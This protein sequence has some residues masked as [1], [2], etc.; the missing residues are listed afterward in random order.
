VA[1]GGGSAGCSTSSFTIAPSSAGGSM[2]YWAAVGDNNGDSWLEGFAP[3]DESV[4]TTLTVPSV[5]ATQYRDSGGNLVSG[6]AVECIGCHSAVPD[7][8]SVAFIDFY[9]WPGSAANVK[10]VG[11]AGTTGQVPSWMTPQGAIQLA[12]PWLGVVTFSEADWMNE[13]VAVTTYGCT[14]PS[15][16]TNLPWRNGCSNQTPSLIW[17]QLDAPQVPAWDAGGFNSGSTAIDQVMAGYGTTWGVIERTGDIAGNGAE[18]A[19]WSHDGSKILYVSTNA[20]KDGRLATGTADLYTVPFNDKKGGAATPVKGASDPA[21]AEYYG[22][23]SKDDS[24]IAFVSAKMQ[25]SQ[26]MYYNPYGEIEVIPA[27]G[28]SAT[29]LVAND[30]VACPVSY[31][32]NGQTMTTTPKSPGV[33]NSWPKWSP[34]VES[35]PDGN[36]YYWIVFSSA[37][38]Y[39]P[40]NNSNFKMGS[41]DGPTSQLYIT[42]ISVDGSGK[43]T[44]YPAL[45]IWNQP[46]TSLADAPVPGQ[47]QSNHTPVWETI[48]IP[49][50][51]VPTV[52]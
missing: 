4:A 22:S 37:R 29:R 43:I 44:S 17:T 23:F 21:V 48:T 49:R 18:F 3:G 19:N 12:M 47:P 32:Q 13:K 6:G 34:D 33:F 2:I 10:P 26:G 7:G 16:T 40:F 31:M 20:G 52:Q 42:A 46:T 38:Q 30:P 45:Y 11:D 8:A 24:Y 9:P 5:Q 25:G 28:G 35:C 51:P 41:S 1:L 14:P 27:G 15:G 39:L 36:T 50:H